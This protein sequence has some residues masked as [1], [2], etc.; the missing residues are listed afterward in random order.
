VKSVIERHSWRKCD[1]DLAVLPDGPI[2]RIS[3]DRGDLVR[4]CMLDSGALEQT[5]AAVQQCLG[6]A[7]VLYRQEVR[8]TRGRRPG[9]CSHHRRSPFSRPAGA[10]WCRIAGTWQPS[11]P[12]RAKVSS[13]CRR[14]LLVPPIGARM[15][16]GSSWDETVSGR[17]DMKGREAPG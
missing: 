2:V 14:T 15:R 5:V 10:D 3:E 6:G 13:R 12:S 17:G 1:M 7:E 16:C 11:L 9:P 4:G 8:Q